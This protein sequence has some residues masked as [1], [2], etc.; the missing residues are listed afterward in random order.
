[1]LRDLCRDRLRP[2]GG[3]GAGPPTGLDGGKSC[4]ALRYR[5]ALGGRDDFGG[6]SDRAR[7]TSMIGGWKLGFCPLSRH[8]PKKCQRLIGRHGWPALSPP[9]PRPTVI[10]VAERQSTR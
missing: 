4:D 10:R 5:S 2:L 7:A 8:A 3:A 9:K 6:S 1:M